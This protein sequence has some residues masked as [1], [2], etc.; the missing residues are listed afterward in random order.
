MNLPS[1]IVTREELMVFRRLEEAFINTWTKGGQGAVPQMPHMP[2]L[3]RG[4][5]FH[6]P[7]VD[8]WLLEFF[9]IGGG[10]R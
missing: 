9:Q 2:N 6:L 5:R 1:T 10:K 7:S 3:G 8:A 4:V